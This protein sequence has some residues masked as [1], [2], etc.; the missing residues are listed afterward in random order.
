MGSFR[1]HASGKLINK[2]PKK[3]ELLG[4]VTGSGNARTWTAA[5]EDVT[6]KGTW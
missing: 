4:K 2:R 3:H 1:F 6:E 5:P